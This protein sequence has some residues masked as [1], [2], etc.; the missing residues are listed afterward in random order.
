MSLFL[1]YLSVYVSNIFSPEA[2]FLFSVFMIC[3]SVLY[4]NI[5]G[6]KYREVFS[7][8]CPNAV[9]GIVV[10]FISTSLATIL[11]VVLKSLFGVLRPE[12]KFIQEVGYSFPS[13]HTSAAFAFISAVIFI[14]FKYYKNHNRV[15]INYLHIS[16]F[17]STALLVGLSRLILE[18][19]R[20]I[21]IVG[22]IVVGLFSTFLSIKIYYN[23]MKYV[24]KKIYK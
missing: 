9:K 14:L 20:P 10:L 13:G 4:F 22:G 24:D 19:H 7:V 2:L 18:V 8:N 21:D 1:I 3:L 16:L 6:I 23:L 12:S 11:T 15:Y 5:K 17:V